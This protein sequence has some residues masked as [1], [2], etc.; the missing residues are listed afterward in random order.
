MKGLLLKSMNIQIGTN[1]NQNIIQHDLFNRLRRYEY[2]CATFDRHNINAIFALMSRSIN[3]EPTSLFIRT[4][5]H[6]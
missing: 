1:D 4:D 6:N 2:M 5:F 3:V